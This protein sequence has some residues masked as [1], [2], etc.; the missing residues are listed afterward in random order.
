MPAN[1]ISA[2]FW[3]IS[4]PKR[5]FDGLRAR[6]RGNHGEIVVCGNTI[7]EIMAE[8]VTRENGIDEV[9]AAIENRRK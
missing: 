1:H 2:T 9:V 8:L 6:N 5:D 3:L 4:C 7:G